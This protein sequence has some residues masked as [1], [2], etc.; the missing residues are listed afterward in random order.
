MSKKTISPRRKRGFGSRR[1][2]VVEQ[3]R[4]GIG[5]VSELAQHLGLT[6]NA[7]RAHLFALER[8]GLVQRQ[9]SE[10]GK[11]R[12]HDL[13]HLTSRAQKLLAQASDASLSALIAAM[14]RRL[15]RARVRTLLQSGGSELA[16]RFANAGRTLSARVRSAARVLNAIGG[17]ARVEK[18]EDGFCI[19]SRGCPLS[20][21]VCEHAEA[22]LF[23][24][25]F[26]ASLIGAPVREHCSRGKQPRC[27]FL[28]A[29]PNAATR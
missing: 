17:S 3:L 12:P 27:R 20:A 13:Y 11:R 14:K 5:T 9:G 8:D 6:D 25:K 4:R 29:D 22:C 23:V 24:E 16:A 10:A 18:T 2:E 1:A 7:V 15:S 28:I 19:R 26:L 21:V